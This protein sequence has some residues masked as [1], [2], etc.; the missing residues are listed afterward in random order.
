MQL[1]YFA[2][3][4]I[5]RAF[6]TCCGVSN[7]VACQEDSRREAALLQH[8][9]CIRI[10]ILVAIVKREH[11]GLGQIPRRLKSIH[12][13]SKTNRAI[14]GLPKP[15]HVRRKYRNGSID[16]VIGM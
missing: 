7:A 15:S 3:G 14:A 10:E 8:R 13:F 4:E 6:D 16:L 11:N 12:H 9:E 5:V 2:P 1:T